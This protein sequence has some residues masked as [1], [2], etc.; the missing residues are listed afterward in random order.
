MAIGDDTSYSDADCIYF[1][2]GRFDAFDN[3][4][5]NVIKHEGLEFYTTEHYYH[6]NKFADVDTELAEVIR[7]ARSPA[8]AHR[9]ARVHRDLIPTDWN[10]RKLDVMR[11]GLEMKLEQHP[12]V[13][14]ALKLT[15]D[16]RLIENSS[17]DLFW[18]IGRSGQGENWMGR[19]WMELRDEILFSL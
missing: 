5:A 13:R 4:S 19:L 3:Y 15:G 10:H 8:E 9:L 7:L 1:Y 14:A 12:D 16:R 11:S 2:I 17:D 6:W 18:G